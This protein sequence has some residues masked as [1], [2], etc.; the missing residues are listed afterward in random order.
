M[1]AL[2]EVVIL[3]VSDSDRSLQFYRHQ[4]GFDL[5]VDHPPADYAGFADFGGSDG[6][7]WV[8]QERIH[9]PT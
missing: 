1:K 8:L 4:I 2:L 5:D 7:R 3:P 6:N 9:Q